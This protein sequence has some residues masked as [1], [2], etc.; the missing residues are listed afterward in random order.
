MMNKT[1]TNLNNAHHVSHKPLPHLPVKPVHQANKAM[2]KVHADHKHRHLGF[3]SCYVTSE[4]I[5]LYEV[6]FLANTTHSTCTLI[7]LPSEVHSHMLHS[8]LPLFRRRKRSTCSQ[9]APGRVQHAVRL[10]PALVARR[11]RQ[12]KL[13]HCNSVF[14]ISKPF[15]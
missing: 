15:G 10:L 6:R 7:V 1:A 3:S 2:E 14:C 13:C 8:H 9:S 5:Y 4:G 12:T 11:N